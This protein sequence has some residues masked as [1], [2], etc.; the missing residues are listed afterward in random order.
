[1][2]PISFQ[3]ALERYSAA[4]DNAIYMDIRHRIVVD[5]FG[6]NAD[7]A[8]HEADQQVVDLMN[9]LQHVC[10]QCCGAAQNRGAHIAF[11][12]LSAWA[13]LSDETINTILAFLWRFEREGST[14]AADFEGTAKALITTH[15]AIKTVNMATAHT[16]G[17]HSWQGRMAYHLLAAVEYLLRASE[18][19]LEHH[20]DG[21]YIREKLKCGLNRITGALYEGVRSSDSPALF[22]FKGTYFPDEKDRR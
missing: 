19:L 6:E 5:I 17:V 13:T 21:D 9:A 20:D 10:L 11:A 1:M 15:Q 18:L 3:Q 14:I 8:V 7:Y 16:N 22:N 4:Y 12:E 2:Q